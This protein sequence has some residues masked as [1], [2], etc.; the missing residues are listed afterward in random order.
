MI[1][2]KLFI[3]TLY[4]TEKKSQNEARKRTKQ[5]NKNKSPELAALRGRKFEARLVY[6]VRSKNTRTTQ[7][8]AASKQT[9]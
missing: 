9:N 7:R 1:R 8:N 6:R 3:L 5:P 4:I 2:I